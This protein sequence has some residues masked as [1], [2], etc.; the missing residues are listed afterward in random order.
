MQHRTLSDL[1]QAPMGASGQLYN[2]DTGYL[3]GFGTTAGNG[4]Q[5]WSP[6]ALFVDTDSNTA[7]QN[8]GTAASATWSPLAV[9]SGASALTT[10]LTN[11]T[12]VA[13]GTPDYAVQTLTNSGGFGFVT[14]DEGL[15]TLSVIQNNKTRIAEIEAALVTA[16]IL[17]A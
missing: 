7:Y 13:P 14:A 9:A 6:G 5:G 3:L 2:S 11:L 10:A 17:A 8:T 4:V 1:E 15:T 12:L 16:G